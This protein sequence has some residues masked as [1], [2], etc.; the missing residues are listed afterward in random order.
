M[1]SNSTSLSVLLISLRFRERSLTERRQI[2][3]V[4][5]GVFDG[6]SVN[7]RRRRRRRRTFQRFGHSHVRLKSVSLKFGR[8]AVGKA[9]Q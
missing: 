8:A 1:T 2:F 5:I 6:R 7:H 9:F 3:V 4:S